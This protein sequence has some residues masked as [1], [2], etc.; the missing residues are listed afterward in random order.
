MATS[1]HAFPVHSTSNTI[2]T[3]TPILIDP[4][5][6]NQV[7]L[8]KD[9]LLVFE[10]ATAVQDG[11]LWCLDCLTGTLNSTCAAKGCGIQHRI[12]MKP[13]IRLFYRSG[14]SSVDCIPSRYCALSCCRPPFISEH[15]QRK[16]LPRRPCPWKASGLTMYFQTT[17]GL[18]ID[19]YTLT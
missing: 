2:N 12:Q 11:S 7:V 19:V 8:W 13:Y 18:S 15:R 9:I 4:T 6:A 10:N 1:T 16:Q 14:H 5:T 17:T 3:G